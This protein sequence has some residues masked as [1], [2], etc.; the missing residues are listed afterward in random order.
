MLSIF[1]E[2]IRVTI[3]KGVYK[4]EK[5]ISNNFEISVY[6][7]IHNQ[8]NN[9]YVDYQLL[10]DTVYNTSKL[11]FI[12]LEEWAELIKNELISLKIKGKL[13]LIINKL[14]PAFENYSVGVVG[15]KLEHIL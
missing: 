3:P 7:E 10:V 6:L 2:K 9:S 4:S 13:S 14:N 8:N 11:E 1:A 15:I 5:I 12:L